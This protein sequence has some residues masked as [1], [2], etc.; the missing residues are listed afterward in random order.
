MSVKGVSDEK[1][2]YI[3]MILELFNTSSLVESGITGFV[4]SACLSCEPK[5]LFRR[6]IEIKV[7]TRN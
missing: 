2:R 6:R 5:M 1:H 7:P 4:C 3:N